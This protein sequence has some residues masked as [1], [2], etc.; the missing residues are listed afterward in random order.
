MSAKEF[1]LHTSNRIELLAKQLAII[2]QERPLPG[3]LDQETVMTLNTGMAKW[4]RF[5]IARSTGIAFGWEFPFPN[6][7]FK[8]IATGFDSRF[9]KCVDYDEAQAQWELY[10]LFTQIGGSPEFS[11]VNAY[12]RRSSSHRLRLST[13]LASLYGKYLLYRPDRIIAWERGEDRGDWQGELWRR[14]C[15]RIYGNRT[16]YLHTASLWELLR[17]SPDA[18]PNGDVAAWPHR[19]SVFG[20]S[21][22]PPVYLDL[23]EAVSYERPVH[24]FLLQPTDL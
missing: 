10:D 22:L 7:L 3:P 17:K 8:R 9:A 11:L 1:Y 16:P 23:L 5:E 12:S 20:V 24:I 19:I 18:R 6:Q 21:S 13:K 14:L 15:R 4:L 2:A